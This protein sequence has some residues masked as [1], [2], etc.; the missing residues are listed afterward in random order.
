MLKRDGAHGRGGTDPAYDGPGASD[1]VEGPGGG[2]DHTHEGRES[3]DS[4]THDSSDDDSHEVDGGGGDDRHSTRSATGT[5][6][7]SEVAGADVM[8]SVARLLEKQQKMMAA[9]VQA[10]ATHSVPPLRRFT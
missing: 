5:P 9:Q 1:D 4:H 6:G 2:N 8:Q 7:S 10:M 3:D